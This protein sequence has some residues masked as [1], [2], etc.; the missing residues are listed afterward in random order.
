MRLALAA[1]L[2]AC[3]ARAPA[4]GEARPPAACATIESPA[5][6]PGPAAPAHARV[7]AALGADRASPEWEELAQPFW[8]RWRVFRIVDPTHPSRLRSAAIDARGEVV[9]LTSTRALARSSPALAC[10]NALSR[11][12]GVRIERGDVD[13]YLAFFLRAHLAETEQFLRGEQDADAVIAHPWQS[14]HDEYLLAQLEAVVDPV[15]DVSRTPRGFAASAFD[16]HWSRGIVHRYDLA[17]DRG[18]EVELRESPWGAQK[19]REGPLSTA[20]CFAVHPDGLVLTAHHAVA[21]AVAITLR[22]ERGDERAATVERSAPEH[23][24]ALLRVEGELPAAL[25]LA[26]R[27]P[28]PGEPVFT[29]AYPGPRLLWSEPELAAGVVRGPGPRPFLVE[30]D[31]PARAG[32]SGAPL[33]DASGRVLG[34]L[35]RITALRDVWR[36]TLVVRAAEVRALLGDAGDAPPPAASREQAIT[37]TRA[38]VC[39]V[40]VELV[41]SPAPAEPGVS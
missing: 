29:L 24:L 37:R 6:G 26:A 14:R 22:F 3:A 7:L 36:G 35:S 38:A 8:P 12:E 4:P 18:G 32:S 40:E 11:S 28:E 13:A 20:S 25:A 31:V 2:C 5:G 16:W 34:M 15:F 27:E 1:A 21:E 9:P 41:D 23:D 33:V 19:P 17:V 10:F 30:T 39:E